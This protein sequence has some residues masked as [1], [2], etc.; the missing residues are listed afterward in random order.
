MQVI[1]SV[2]AEDSPTVTPTPSVTPSVSPTPTAQPSNT[3]NPSVKPTSGPASTTPATNAK[4]G[5]SSQAGYL[6]VIFS[7]AAVLLLMLLWIRRQH[8]KGLHQEKIS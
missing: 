8:R 7:G 4:T 3:P 2:V 1:A 5:D 6:A